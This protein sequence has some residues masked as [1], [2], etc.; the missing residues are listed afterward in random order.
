MVEH[1]YYIMFGRKVIQPPEDIDSPTF[2]PRLRAY[3]AQRGMI[4]DVAKKFTKSGFNLKVAFKALIL[5]DFYRVDGLGT[6]AKNPLRQAELDDVGIVRLLAPEQL[7]RKLNAIFGKHWQRLDGE[8]RILYGGIDSQTVTER[9]TDPSGAMGAIQRI[10]AN[11]IAC[12]YV[13]KEFQLEADKRLLFPGIEPSVV[14]G[15]KMSDKKIREA[16]VYLSQ[17][18]LGQE[19]AIDHPDIERTF[20]LFEGI[21]AD[22]RSRG[23]FDPRETYFCGGG[24]GP[25]VDDPHYTIRGWRGVVTYMLRQHDFLYE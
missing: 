18:L 23:K 15:E 7:D 20:G 2:T 21:L 12:K 9:N 6:L 1:V 16:I 14:P 8:L 4:E 24:E 5:G 22:A 17:R 19:R 11:D 13:G 10:M 3:R 25:R